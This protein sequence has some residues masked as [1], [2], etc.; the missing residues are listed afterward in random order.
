MKIKKKIYPTSQ[1]LKELF[2]D[3]VLSASYEKL[4]ARSNSAEFHSV[5][6]DIQRKLN[7]LWWKTKDD[8]Q[9]LE[10]K[11]VFESKDG[12]NIGTE[13]S[14]YVKMKNKLIIIKKLEKKFNLCIN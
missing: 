2:E 10:K 5:Y 13:N 9:T 8:L 3:N 4:K 14:E 1:L 12:I 6:C 11:A 7:D